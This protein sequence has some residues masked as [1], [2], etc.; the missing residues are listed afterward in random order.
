[1]HNYKKYITIIVSITLIKFYYYMLIYYNFVLILYFIIYITFNKNIIKYFLSS[2]LLKKLRNK[3][4][5]FKNKITKTKVIH[6][7]GCYS[8]IKL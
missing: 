6:D 7:I 8:R 3:N 4:N 1:M 2:L 5:F